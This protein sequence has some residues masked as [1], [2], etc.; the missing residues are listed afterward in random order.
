MNHQVEAVIQGG[1]K[2]DG[3]MGLHMGIA[4]N[5]VVPTS[6]TFGAPPAPRELKVDASKV[7][8]NRG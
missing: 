1:S 3:R 4:V 2:T 5:I 8:V 7:T 6:V